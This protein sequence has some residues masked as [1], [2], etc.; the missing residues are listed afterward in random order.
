[1]GF[2]RLG[3]RA[4]RAEAVKIFAGLK[5]FSIQNS[6]VW[7][8]K[9]MACDQMAGRWLDFMYLSIF[10]FVKVPKSSMPAKIAKPQIAC[11]HATP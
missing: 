6:V 3:L 9:R 11:S 5:S 1:M 10:N 7:S 2:L 8:C 4:A